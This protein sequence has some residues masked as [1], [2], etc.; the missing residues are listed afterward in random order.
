MFSIVNS[1]FYEWKY[2]TVCKEGYSKEQKRRRRT[3]EEKKTRIA[4][5]KDNHRR[6]ALS[7]QYRVRI[8]EKYKLNRQHQQSQSD[9]GQRDKEEELGK[10]GQEVG[11]NV[12]ERLLVVEEMNSHAPKSWM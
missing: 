1:L 8:Y 3:G 5:K 9:D 6:A 4:G 2:C 11:Q 12:A 10:K 7:K